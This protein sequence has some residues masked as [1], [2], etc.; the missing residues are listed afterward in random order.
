MKL[1]MDYNLLRETYGD[2]E[3][4]AVAK[5]AGFDAID[6]GF[7]NMKGN[8]WLLR[9][10]YREY[11]QKL[12][13]AMDQAGI[14]CRQTHAPFQFHYGCAVDESCPEYLETVRAIEVSAILGAKYTV[15]H[16]V[17]V[18]NEVSLHD[19][20]L[21]FYRT[22]I[23]YCAKF[24]VQVAVENLFYSDP[25]TGARRGRLARPEELQGIVRELN[26]PWFVICV[27]VGHCIL[28]GQ[29][30]ENFIEA[31]D[32]E[33]LKVLHIQD[34]D[35]LLDRHTMPY[36]GDIHWD[37]V[38][39]A[40]KRKGYTGDL[41]YEIFKFFKKMPAALRFDALVFTEKVGRHLIGLY[42]KA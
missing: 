10:D 4:F 38:M 5:N 42:E 18:P 3:G 11:A 6:Y 15:I 33:L 16:A 2:L 20:N 23:P 9:S 28:T 1:A 27:D 40:L 12:R 39:A 17:V 41:T 34:T 7:Y 25:E 29:Q 37:A 21:D 36:L 22:F 24:G 26:S 31:I 8:N 32:G 14:V 35:D 30:P 19:Y 13:D